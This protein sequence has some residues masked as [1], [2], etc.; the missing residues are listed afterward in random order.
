MTGALY[1]FE[2]KTQK[3]LVDCG[4]L[5]GSDEAEASNALPF[6]FKASDVDVVFL[7]HAHL[8][9]SGRIPKL[10]KD[11]FNGT[12]YSTAP[13]H[14]EAGELLLDAHKIMMHDSDKEEIYDISHVNTAIEHWKTVEYRKPFEI[15]DITVEFYN[16]GHILGAASIKISSD[17]TSVVV[18]GD[19]GNIPVPMIRDTDYPTGVSYALIESAYG[20]R[21]HEPIE[22]RRGLLENLI[23]DTVKAG[24]TLMIPAFALE[25]TQ[26]LLYE[27]NEL[28]EGGRIPEIPIYID[29]PLAIKLTSVYEKYSHNPEFFEPETIKKI[30]S[31]D[32]I[33]NFPHLHLTLTTEESKEI[34]TISPPKVVIAGSGMSVG[35]RILHHER[36]YLSDPKST[37]LFVGFQPAGSL[38]RQIIDGAKEVTIMGTKVPVN[39]RVEVIGGY[40]AHADQPLLLEW[41]RHIKDTVKKVFIVQGELDQS[42]PLASKIKDEFAIDA[43]VPD[44]GQVIE[45]S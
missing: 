34:N 31:G 41:V 6:P 25:R 20:N 24:G 1:L 42:L 14:D 7:T 11:G 44:P 29:S 22:K 9:H 15:G 12:I 38:G 43:I 35:G 10:I 26:Q 17:T 23:E 37:I 28:V 19:L 33:F 2:T 40:S 4:L 32:E 21:V 36:N 16:A 39:A 13:A 3:V 8:D 5:Q 27:L 45:L 30:E 18:S